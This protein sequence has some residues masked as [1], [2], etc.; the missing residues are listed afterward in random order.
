MRLLGKRAQSRVFTVE[1]LG[2]NVSIQREQPVEIFRELFFCSVHIS[3]AKSLS[4]LPR[5]RKESFSFAIVSRVTVL[6]FLSVSL[7][8]SSI[9]EMQ[10]V[11]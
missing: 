11:R 8:S 6:H 1:I 7:K 9:S 4:I 5:M 2:I 10:A 3:G